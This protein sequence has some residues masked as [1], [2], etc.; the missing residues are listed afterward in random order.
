MRGIF[1]LAENRQV[2]KKDSLS[3]ELV[4]RCMNMSTDVY[5]MWGFI[6]AI[7]KHFDGVEKLGDA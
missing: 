4:S 2:F 5:E 3:M 1:R 6:S 7:T